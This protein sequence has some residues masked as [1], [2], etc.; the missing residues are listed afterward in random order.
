MFRLYHYY[1]MGASTLYRYTYMYEIYIYAYMYIIFCKDHDR[2]TNAKLMKAALCRDLQIRAFGFR[3]WHFG[4]VGGH[5]G[6]WAWDTVAPGS[7]EG[8]WLQCS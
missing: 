8:S 4:H 1:R 7:E 3:V 6:F 2:G 5:H